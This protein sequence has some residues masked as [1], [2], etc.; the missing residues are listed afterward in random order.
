[1]KIILT[2]KSQAA[3]FIFVHRRS[4]TQN[5]KV[6]IFTLKGSGCNT[7]LQSR[8]CGVASCQVMGFL[9]PLSLPITNYL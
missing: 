4:M 5:G 6:H 3:N 8:D 9:S 1:M 7:T 2:V